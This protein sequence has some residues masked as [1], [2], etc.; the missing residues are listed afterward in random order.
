[1]WRGRVS[2]VVL[3]CLLGMATHH[4]SK[5]F[6]HLA[7]EQPPRALADYY[8]RRV[9]NAYFLDRVPPQSQNFAYLSADDPTLRPLAVHAD[10]AERHGADNFSGL[11]PWTYL[12]QLGIYLPT[13]DRFAR[14]YLA[15]LDAAALAIMAS[16]AYNEA[17]RRQVPPVGRTIAVLAVLAIGATNEALSDGQTSLV[18]NAGLAAAFVA[19]RRPPSRT[20][21]II[22]GAGLS[23]ALIKPT[24]G[25]LFLL[26]ALARRRSILIATCAVVVTTAWL[27]SA[28]WVRLPPWFQLQQFERATRLVVASRGA[29]VWLQELSRSLSPQLAR[30][31]F[32]VAG[33]GFGAAGAY[34]LRTDLPATFAFLAIVSRLYTYHGSYD[35]VLLAFLVIHLSSLALAPTASTQK[36]LVWLLVGLSLWLP[37]S[38]YVPATARWIQSLCWFA[39]ALWAL[40]RGDIP[41]E[42]TDRSATSNECRLSPT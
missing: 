35:D 29:N 28:W 39:A 9:D 36:I 25:L 26:P 6:Y 4:L 32:C 34:R 27:V 31:I 17:R 24:L 30:N 42:E 37:F 12:L 2:A 15:M 33:I 40:Q 10:P 1:V 14:I 18:I 41:V 8:W 13:F 21:D 23:I 11:P 5:G 7:V 16:L 3:L 38:V 19:L 20:W 22:G